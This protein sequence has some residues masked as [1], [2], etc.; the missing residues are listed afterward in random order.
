MAGKVFPVLRSCS[1]TFPHHIETIRL[2][3]VT[4]PACTNLTYDSNDLD[5]LRCFHDLPL[6]YLIVNSGQ[7]NVRRGNH[8]LISICHMVLP[9][10]ESL[11]RLDLQVQCSEQLLAYMLS[12]LPALEVL[13]LRLACPRALNEAF[14]QKFVATKSN[15]DSQCETGYLHQTLLQQIFGRMLHSE[16]GGWQV[17]ILGSSKLVEDSTY[18]SATAH[19]IGP[20]GPVWSGSVHRQEQCGI[21]I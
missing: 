15:A 20:G 8:Q 9:C 17:P 13:Y 5:P 7:W 18:R 19:C 21:W 11:T 10:A 1:I 12:L 16:H 6:K 4:M 14:F 2:Q 3:P